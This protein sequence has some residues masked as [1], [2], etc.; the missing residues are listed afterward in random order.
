MNIVDL[1]PAAQRLAH[2]VARVGDDELSKPT[3]CPEYTLGDLID[4]V[5][6]LALAFTAAAEKDS[7]ADASQGPSGD[8]PRLGD[9]WRTRIPRDLQALVRAWRE[10][11]AWTGMTRI[12][13][14]DTPAPMAGLAVADELAVHGWD[15]ARA[16]GQRYGCEPDLLTAARSFLIQFAS[17]DAPP[18]PDVPFGPS[19]QLPGGATLLDRAVA[20][21]GRDSD[22]SPR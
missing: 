22:W 6:G 11:D 1:G 7:G 14:L 21:A 20:L 5:G 2:L 9:D 4:H 12:A 19:R 13:G 3:P 17:P 16:S 10:P 15:V 18:D 8:A